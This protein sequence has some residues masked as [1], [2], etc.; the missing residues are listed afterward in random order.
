[1]KLESA[2]QSVPKKY[3][4]CKSMYA[5]IDELPTS[6]RALSVLVNLGRPWEYLTLNLCAISS[7]YKFVIEISF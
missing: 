2:L 5:Y 6:P 3:N 4:F 1:M 7:L